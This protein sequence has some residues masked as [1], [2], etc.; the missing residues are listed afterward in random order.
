MMRIGLAFVFTVFLGFG[1]GIGQTETAQPVDEHLDY[2]VKTLQTHPLKLIRKN[3]ARNL[4][5]LGKREAVGALVGAL[6]DTDSGVRAEAAR[7]L[8]LLGDERAFSTLTDAAANDADREVR[9][10]A[11][12]S[13]EKI[14]SYLE[15]QK[16][17]EL[18]G[19]PQVPAE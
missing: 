10:A 16:Q 13:I 8:G 12:D 3:A 14:K 19:Q 7:S 1:L 2:W 4:G 11:A 6:K 17:K 5:K 9:R 18:K 15:F